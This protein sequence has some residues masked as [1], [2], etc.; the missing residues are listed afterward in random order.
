MNIVYYSFCALSVFFAYIAEKKNSKIVLL[1]SIF[2]I[3][4]ISGLRAST[5]GYDTEGYYLYIDWIRMGILKNVE[6]G[7]ILFTKVL[8]CFFD[9]NEF[10]IFIYSSLTLL[11]CYARFWSF[12]NKAS[13]SLIIYIF[14]AFYIQSSMNIMRQFFAISIVFFASYFLEKKKYFV[15]LILTALAVTFHIVAIVGVLLF[16]VY[17]RYSDNIKSKGVYMLLLFIA[18]VA[19][20][21]AMRGQLFE[22]FTDYFDS[23]SFDIGFM[24][25]F[26]ILLLLAFV[27]SNRMEFRFASGKSSI[28]KI[29]SIIYFLGLLFTS[30]GYIFPFMDRVGLVCMMF[31][32]IC[33]AMMCK[34]RNKD[35]FRVI[36]ILLTGFFIITNMRA[37]GYGVFPYDW[38]L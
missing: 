23:I 2:F 7:F 18:S 9:S 3:C 38:V 28:I 29:V 20:I 6:P 17:L 34:Y 21:I 36:T 32:P 19:L 16:L 8:L 33:F 1:I 37:N 13:F 12:R 24:V 11:L 25:V 5:V 31:E 26:K 15:F 30:L 14:L 22:K 27:F 4:F 10:V 35:V